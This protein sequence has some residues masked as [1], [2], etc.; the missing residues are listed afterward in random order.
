MDGTMNEINICELV[1]KEHEI[2]NPYKPELKDGRVIHAMKLPV[3][4]CC[5]ARKD[6][7]HYYV[8]VIVDTPYISFHQ[9]LC[10]YNFKKN[11]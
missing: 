6:I 10:G 1:R 5:D 11:E 8:N 4:L 2:D 9:G 7:C 3:Y